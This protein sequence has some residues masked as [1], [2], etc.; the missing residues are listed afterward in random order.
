MYKL[1]AG[2]K[3]DTQKHHVGHIV[4]YCTVHVHQLNC[5]KHD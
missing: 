5:T 4:K 1:T 2:V 3:V